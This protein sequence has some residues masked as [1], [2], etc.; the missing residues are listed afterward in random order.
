MYT[1]PRGC[2]DYFWQDELLH[3]I[4]RGRHND[5]LRNEEG[6]FLAIRAIPTRT[7]PIERE[8]IRQS[9]ARSLPPEGIIPRR[10]RSCSPERERALVLRRAPSVERIEYLEPCVPVL[11]R[12]YPEY[13]KRDAPWFS[14]TTRYPYSVMDHHRSML[15]NKPLSFGPKHYTSLSTFP[16]MR[17]T[18]F[19]LLE[20]IERYRYH[21]GHKPYASTCNSY[22]GYPT[23]SVYSSRR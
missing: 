9:R 6:R 16:T 22:L 8:F 12:Y 10:A 14:Y 15:A 18:S 13:S 1:F 11:T 19:S 3:S 4:I 23:P 17:H 2:Y 21:S 20:P 5:R 7:P